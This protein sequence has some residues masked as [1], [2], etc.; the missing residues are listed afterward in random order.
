MH[1]QEVRQKNLEAWGIAD[2]VFILPEQFAQPADR[3]RL[4]QEL[5]PDFLAVSSHSSHLEV[6]AQL[7]EKYGGKL[8]I[9][10][11]HNPSISTTQI[12]QANATLR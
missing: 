12:L 6:K 2:R 8:A 11:Q 5:R 7:M 3:E 1:S 9:V 4:L 10:H